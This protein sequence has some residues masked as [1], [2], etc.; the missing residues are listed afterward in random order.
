MSNSLVRQTTPRY[1]R[2]AVTIRDN[3]LNCDACNQPV[4]VGHRVAVYDTAPNI[5]H[6]PH[7]GGCPPAWTPVVLDGTP[8]TR[9][10]Q[11]Q[12]PLTP[13]LRLVADHDPENENPE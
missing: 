4:E 8:G 13:A 1:S 11:L 3:G 2:L 5:V 6:H 7:D 9:S 12:L 10:A